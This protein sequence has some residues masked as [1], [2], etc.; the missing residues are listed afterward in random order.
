MPI[1]HIIGLPGAGKTTLCRQLGP[2]LGWE[3]LRIGQ[4]RRLRPP[5]ETG[6]ADAW[7]ALYQALSRCRWEQVILETTGLNGRLCFLRQAFA[8]GRV[9]TL[10]LSCCRDELLRRIERRPAGEETNPWFYADCLPDRQAFISRLFEQFTKLP[11]ELETDTTWLTPDEVF[12]QAVEKIKAWSRSTWP[13]LRPEDSS[14][15]PWPDSGWG[16]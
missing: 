1:L 4:F 12:A 8:P 6:E 11:A 14:V 5:S 7:L 3:V 15:N 2:L 16:Q 13:L 9:V 10:K